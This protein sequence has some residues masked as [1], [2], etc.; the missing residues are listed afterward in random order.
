[1]GFSRVHTWLGIRLS[2]SI[3]S[4]RPDL[5][6]SIGTPDEEGVRSHALE[7]KVQVDGF[8]SHPVPKPTQLKPIS[9]W[10]HWQALIISIR[11]LIEIQIQVTSVQTITNLKIGFHIDR[12][13][14]SISYPQHARPKVRSQFHSGASRSRL[15]YGFWAYG[16]G[17]RTLGLH[18]LSVFTT[19]QNRITTGIT[20]Q[21]IFTLC[22]YHPQ[23]L[24]LK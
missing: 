21:Q 24:S 3:L 10:Y 7:I 6:Q 20:M 4:A 13:S 16:L 1:M 18:Q 11:E 8:D 23:L 12:T 15:E 19:C 17:Q 2:W 22:Y 5:E 9:D 14:A